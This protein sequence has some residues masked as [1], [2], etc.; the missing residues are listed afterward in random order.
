MY[1]AAHRKWCGVLALHTS[2]GRECLATTAS[3]QTVWHYD[4]T[5]LVGRDE[6]SLPKISKIVPQEKSYCLPVGP[7]SCA[8]TVRFGR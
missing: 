6:K 3:P 2:L 1:L 5:S 8:G 7:T 4:L